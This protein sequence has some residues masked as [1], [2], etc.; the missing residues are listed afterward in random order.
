M[1][2]RPAV[3]P[4]RPQDW[5]QAA[6]LPEV[7]LRVSRSSFEHVRFLRAEGEAETTGSEAGR[8]RRI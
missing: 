8:R 2:Q 7:R 3:T 6:R 4:L 1:P 5:V